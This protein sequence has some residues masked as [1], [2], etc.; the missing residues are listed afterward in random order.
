[1]QRTLPPRLMI[2]LFTP[3]F[4]PENLS[5]GLQYSLWQW[6]LHRT[7]SVIRGKCDIL[8]VNGRRRRSCTG[9]ELSEYHCI[10]PVAFGIFCCEIPE[11]GQEAQWRCQRHRPDSLVIVESFRK[12]SGKVCRDIMP[13]VCCAAEP[14]YGRSLARSAIGYLYPMYLLR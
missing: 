6:R 5:G 9:G 1:M 4:L 14:G 3:L 10:M 12:Q 8:P 11:R 7:G 2:A 13:G